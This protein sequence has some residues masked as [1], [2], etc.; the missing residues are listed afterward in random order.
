M[1]H[2]SIAPTKRGKLFE[3]LLQPRR[4][5]SQH[6]V[7]HKAHSIASA[8]ANDVSAVASRLRDAAIRNAEFDK[9]RAL[10]WSQHLQAAASQA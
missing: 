5:G 3:A 8:G 10:R 7:A 9:L 6:Q 1:S 2:A 4:Q